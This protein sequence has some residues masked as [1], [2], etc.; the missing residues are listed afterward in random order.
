MLGIHGSIMC[1]KFLENNLASD[2]ISGSESLNEAFWKIV[3]WEDCSRK[4][5]AIE[6]NGTDSLLM[7]ISKIW[8]GTRRRICFNTASSHSSLLSIILYGKHNPEK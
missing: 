4:W 2:D 1:I 5:R 8:W 6:K 7:L 3:S